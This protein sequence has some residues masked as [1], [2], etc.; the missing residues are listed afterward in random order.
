MLLPPGCTAVMPLSNLLSCL[1]Q[2]LMHTLTQLL[3]LP[4]R[5]LPST[6][7]SPSS[8]LHCLRA[9]HC[10]CRHAVHCHQRCHRCIAVVPSIA[11]TV[12]PSIAA[13]KVALPLHLPLP[14]PSSHPLSPLPLLLLLH[15]PLPLDLPLPL[16]LPSPSHCRRTFRRHRVA[17]ALW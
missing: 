15:R 16:C 17:V 7:P 6:H 13:V 1:C 11:V 2:V 9:F 4:C 12:M 8:P 5:L 3:L 10:R 14:L